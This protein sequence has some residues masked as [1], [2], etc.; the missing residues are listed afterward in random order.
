MAVTPSGG[1]LGWFDG[2]FATKPG[3]D[4]KKTGY[5]QQRWIVR[6]VSEFFD[7]V[8]E[9]M[10]LGKNANSG[11]RKVIKGDDGWKWVQG[12]EGDTYGRVGWKEIS[13]GEHIR[14]AGSSGILQ[15]L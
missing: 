6:P 15:G 1:H 11:G 13:H 3:S 12:S 5:P 4:P 9:G 14:G 7:S 2:P 10:E 8:I